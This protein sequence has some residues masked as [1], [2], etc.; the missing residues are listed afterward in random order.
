[1]VGPQFD[2]DPEIQDVL[3]WKDSPSTWRLG[4]GG[5]DNELD[6]RFIPRSIL[7]AKFKAPLKVEALLHALFGT[8][9]DPLPDA[10]YIRNRYLRP[11]VILLFVGQG[12]MI[13]HFV[14]HESLQ[15]R[16]LPFRAL[17]QG[18]PSSTTC[19]LWEI[20]EREQW[21]FCAMGLEY[22][23]S[24]HLGTDDILPIVHK[25]RLGEGGSA[26][27]HRITVHPDYDS[28]DPPGSLTSVRFPLESSTDL[29]VVLTGPTEF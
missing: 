5:V 1:M 8:S 14:E 13:Y 21:G 25:E 3:S 17:P 18:F 24:Y 6:R 27:T 22:N 9:N 10:D 16:H 20:F 29:A 4:S 2:H 15:D 28:L 12:Q 19:N 7:E 11:F 23:M 26:V